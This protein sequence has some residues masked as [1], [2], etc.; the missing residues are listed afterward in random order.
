[1]TRTS[2][3][4]RLGVAML[5]VDPTIVNVAIPSIID[6]LGIELVDGSGST[7]STGRFSPR[8]SSRWD[9]SATSPV[10][11]NSSMPGW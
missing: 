7:P 6:D 10:G 5:N 8:F 3:V 9:A 1:M 11:T 4:R 2:K